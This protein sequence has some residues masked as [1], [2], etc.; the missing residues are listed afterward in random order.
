MNFCFVFDGLGCGGI[1]RVGVDYCNALAK[2]GHGVTVVNLVP[3]MNE[4]VPQLSE[5]V[6]YL[7]RAF[8]RALAPERYCTLVK[9]ASWGR[10][11]YPAAYISCSMVVAAVKPIARR[12]L[13][14]FDVAIAFSGHYND[15]TFV[16]TGCVGAKRRIAWLHG[17]I[18]SYA[19]ISDGYLNLYKHFDGL[20]CLGDEGVEE[21]EYANSYLTYRI[22]KIYNPIKIGERSIEEDGFD[23]LIDERSPFALMV[24]RL[25]YPQKDPYT[26]INAIGLINEHYGHSLN[27]VIVGDGPCR[28]DV[29][30]LIDELGL[31]N[32]VFL[33]GY[34]DN[35]APYYAACKLVIHASA[36]AEGLPTVMLEGMAFGK[37]VV[38]TDVRTGPKE[39][40]G[41]NEF[42]LLC[43]PKDPEDMARQVSALLD[44][45]DLYSH[46]AEKSLE[47]I[48]DFTEDGAISVF[49]GFLNELEADSVID[50]GC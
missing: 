46:Y 23:R 29:E 37:P 22:K 24:A 49:L 21:F 32:N 18:N 20:V 28:P 5:S 19:L 16:G 38:A 13:S 26:V 7:T 40:L 43:R 25:D 2:R 45:E 3:E 9:R 42:G 35:P 31:G 12:G 44:D 36:S 8:P 41:N 10:F 48:S 6:V 17:G 30:R 27:L 50:G 14:G 34:Q 1:E 47:R 15:L 33:A 4:F 11:V 39:I